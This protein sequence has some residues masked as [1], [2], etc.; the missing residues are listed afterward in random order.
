VARTSKVWLPP[1]SALSVS[2]EE[3]DAQLPPSMRHSNVEPVSL[4]LNANVG[5]VSFVG[6]AGVVS[7][8]VFGAVRSTAQ[9]YVAGVPSVFPAASVARTSNVWLP[10]ASAASVSGEAQDEKLSPSTRH[11]NVEPVS[12]ELKPNVGVVSLDGSGGVVSIVVLGAVLSTRRFVTTLA[13]V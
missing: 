8:V 3:H 4:E 11:S 9:V 2:G 1:P 7:M 10:P 5:V 6:S 12:L 13:D